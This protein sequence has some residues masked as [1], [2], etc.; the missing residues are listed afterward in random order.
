[1]PKHLKFIISAAAALALFAAFFTFYPPFHGQKTTTYTSKLQENG[2]NK[3]LEDFYRQGREL[4][5]KTTASS[6]V[7]FLAVGDIMLSRG[8]AAQ[9]KTGDTGA[10]FLGMAGILLSTDFNFANL[11]SPVGNVT[12]GHSMI[13]G[14]PEENIAA[15]AK[16]NF[17]VVNLA[18]NHAMDQGLPGLHLT[19]NV[20]RKNHLNYTGTGGSLYSAW[21]AAV[22]SKN[23][24]KICFVGASYAS[25]NDNGKTFNNYVARIEDTERLKAAITAARARCDFVVATMHAG[26][27][28]TRAPNA[29]Q[30]QFAHAAIDDGADMVIGAHPHWVQ[31]IER[32]CP[33]GSAI[34]PSSPENKKEDADRGQSS[35]KLKKCASSKFIFYSL[36]NFIF[37]QMWSQDTRE[38]LALKIQLSKNQTPNSLAV[39]PASAD[40]LQ[41]SRL[42]ARL[43]SVRL[44]P[45]VIE[46]S[47]S[48]RPATEEE[49]AKILKK[50]GETE[51]IIRP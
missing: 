36:G 6:T 14:A 38:G 3:S 1:M 48:P 34:M 37:D 41:G 10:P 27:E 7:D 30:I 15:L 33:G 12:G 46:N 31:T 13:F 19:E 16:F 29:A 42:P 17:S 20:L 24:I 50:I 28:Y 18:N 45:V 5:E 22:F 25:I 21:E 40:D 9:I 51:T 39:N 23:G 44:I 8:V 35:D 4:A 11:E 2:Q 26:T 47:S 43:D 32:Y 49:A